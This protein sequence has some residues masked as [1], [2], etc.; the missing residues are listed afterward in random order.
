[1]NISKGSNFEITGRSPG[2]IFENLPDMPLRVVY[3]SQFHNIFDKF[4]PFIILQFD[5]AF[6]YRLPLITFALE[7]DGIRI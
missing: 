4:L 5:M 6:M 3:F 7:R 2:A 1:L